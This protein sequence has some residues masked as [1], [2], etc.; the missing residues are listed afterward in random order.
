MNIEELKQIF[1]DSLEV[2]NVDFDNLNYRD[3][4]WDS[5]SHMVLISAIEDKYDIMLDVD[6]VIALS[7][8]NKCVEI[9]SKY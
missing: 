5:V 3:Q 1:L 6:D 4:G 7:S 9:L 8:F 2:T